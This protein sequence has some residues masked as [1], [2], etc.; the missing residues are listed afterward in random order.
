MVKNNNFPITYVMHYSKLIEREKHLKECLKNIPRQ[1][2][3]IT[4]FDQE[5]LTEELIKESYILDI[6]RYE[7]AI[8][9]GYAGNKKLRSCDISLNLKHYEAMKRFIESNEQVAL[10]LE[11]DIIPTPNYIEQIK[12]II[13]NTPSDYDMIFIGLG[14]GEKF[15]KERIKNAK[16]IND[17]CYEMQSTNCTEAYLISRNAAIKLYE[18]F[19]PFSL[20]IDWELG[21]RIVQLNLKVFWWFPHIFEQGSSNG[22]FKSSLRNE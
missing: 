13:L 15:R 2:I 5:N 4:E 3:I 19:L 11:D 6:Q 12:F 8:K 22:K 16:K 1:P 14:N 9:F 20:P 10:F 7:E 17:Y 21:Y 18:N